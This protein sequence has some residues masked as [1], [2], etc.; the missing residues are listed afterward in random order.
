M[1]ESG[2]NRTCNDEEEDDYMADLSVFV[3]NEVENLQKKNSK[4]VE[5]KS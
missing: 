1:A 5:L 2:T 4:K 3:P